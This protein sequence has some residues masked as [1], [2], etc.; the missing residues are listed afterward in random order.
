MLDLVVVAGASVARFAI[1]EIPAIT[2]DPTD[3]HVNHLLV[4]PSL[5]YCLSSQFDVERRLGISWHTRSLGLLLCL[6][7]SGHRIILSNGC[8]PNVRS[9]RIRALLGTPPHV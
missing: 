5:K 2:T 4:C 7:G 3:E 1:G 8:C 9:D 6:F